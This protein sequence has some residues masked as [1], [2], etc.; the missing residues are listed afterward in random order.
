M[1]TKNNLLPAEVNGFPKWEYVAAGT[2]SI[3]DILVAR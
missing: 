3:V 1:D 2:Y